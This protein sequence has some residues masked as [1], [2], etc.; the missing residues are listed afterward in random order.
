M[1]VPSILQETELGSYRYGFM[2]L[3]I[4]STEPATQ[5]LTCHSD[6]LDRVH[7]HRVTDAIPFHQRSHG[8]QRA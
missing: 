2:A 8:G 5:R 6:D 1:Y 4:L 3:G 7:R